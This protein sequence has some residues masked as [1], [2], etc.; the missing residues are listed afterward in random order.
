MFIAMLAFAH[1]LFMLRNESS[2]KKLHLFP[3]LNMSSTFFSNLQ[4]CTQFSLIFCFFFVNV[5]ESKKKCFGSE[6]EIFLCVYFASLVSI[7]M[8][9]AG[10]NYKPRRLPANTLRLCVIT[11]FAQP[12]NIRL[13]S[14]TQYRH[15]YRRLSLFKCFSLPL[16]ILIKR[17]IR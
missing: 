6:N 16:N 5:R 3:K 13:S 14:T 4:F 11:K 9:A 7:M 15:R 1:I 2:E 17:I 8:L 12:S 10:S